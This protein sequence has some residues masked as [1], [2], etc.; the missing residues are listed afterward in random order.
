MAKCLPSKCLSPCNP[1][2]LDTLG[3][4]PVLSTSE[5]RQEI[6]RVSW[7][8]RL[9]ISHTEFWAQLREPASMSKGG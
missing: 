3:S 7:L 9:T 6:H 2:E 1:E 5:G 8:E 4:L